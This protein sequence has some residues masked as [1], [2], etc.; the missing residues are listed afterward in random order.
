M[1]GSDKVAVKYNIEA[2]ETTV[3]SF[4]CDCCDESYDDV[5][6]I[7]EMLH[8]KHDCGYN[9]VFGDGNEIELVMCETCVK[10]VLG[11]YIKCNVK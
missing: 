7:Q 5:F 3:K 1:L 9:S 10:N 8:F 11:K 2:V 4:T 6:D